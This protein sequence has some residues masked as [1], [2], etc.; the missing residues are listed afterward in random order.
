MKFVMSLVLLI[1]TLLV[2]IRSQDDEPTNIPTSVPTVVPTTPTSDPTSDPTAPTV[3]PT[4]NPTMNPTSDPTDDVPTTTDG[5]PSWRDGL[6]VRTF[7]MIC[8][9]F[10]QFR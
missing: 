1:A 2:G 7:G 5:S 6:F 9:H 8:R 10:N 4:M 3:L